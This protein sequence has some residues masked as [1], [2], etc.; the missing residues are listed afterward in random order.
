[1]WLTHFID[2]K[3]G[4]R[5][6]GGALWALGFRPF[7]LA[8]AGFGVVAM[9]LWLGT[10][11]GYSMAGHSSQVIGILWHVHEMIFGFAAAII[12]GFLLTAVRAWTSVNP[13]KG[14]G[15]ASLWLLWLAGRLVVWAAPEAIA[16]AVDI[17]FLPVAAL[18]LL[19]V[20]I[21]AKN[22]HNIFLPVALGILAIL[23]VLFHLWAA[24]GRSDLAL[25]TSYLAV[26]ILVMFVTIIGGRII[27][28]FT[29]NAIPGFLTRQWRVIEALVI[30][31]SALV[32][33]FDALNAPRWS[34]TT[35]AWTAAIVHVMRIGGWRSWR[36]GYRPVL[37]IL[38]IAYAWI[39]V[40]FLLLGLSS[41]NLV[42]HTVA[43]HAFTVGAVGCAIA[44]M[45][46]RTALG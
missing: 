41:L 46:T 4:L 10:L 3:T 32:F 38:H 34:V 30:P 9:L 37:S 25:R 21:H 40:G 35:A 36:V 5:H 1:M 26:G 7:Y 11:A 45:I 43:I 22:R 44:A 27:P 8:G 23:N 33:V 13:A 19:R 42:A 6:T 18:V 14:A 31:V 15:L 29:M 16:A 17:A 2:R 24:Q 12:V 39:P 20:L 28:S